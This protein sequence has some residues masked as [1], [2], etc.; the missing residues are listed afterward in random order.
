MNNDKYVYDLGDVTVT[1][2]IFHDGDDRY[3]AVVR[4]N[5]DTPIVVAPADMTNT[6]E[7]FWPFI[8]APHD[9]DGD[10]YRISMDADGRAFMNALYN[11]DDGLYIARTEEQIAEVDNAFDTRFSDQ[12]AESRSGQER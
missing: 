4:N 11:P 10:Q 7:L 2:G 12:I 1:D 9:S 6:A 3:L 5:T 8:L